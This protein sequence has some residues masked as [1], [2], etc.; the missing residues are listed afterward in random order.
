VVAVEIWPE[1]PPRAEPADDIAAALA[2]DPVAA[3]FFDSLAQFY[4]KAYV[5]WIDSAERDPQP[6]AQRVAEVIELL[7][8][9]VK[10]RTNR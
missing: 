9:R 2:A 6:R 7:R 3:S 5:R 8:A 10:Q 4:R 1:G